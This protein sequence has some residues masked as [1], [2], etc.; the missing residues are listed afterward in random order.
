[1]P[2]PEARALDQW[3]KDRAEDKERKERSVIIMPLEEYK[4]YAKRNIHNHI[5]YPE[6]KNV[7]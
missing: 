3:V 5:I 4:D 2:S 1:M 6:I 7:N